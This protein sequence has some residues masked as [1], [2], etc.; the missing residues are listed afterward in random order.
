[1]MSNFKFDLLDVYVFSKLTRQPFSDFRG[2][3]QLSH[4]SSPS[5]TCC[6]RSSQTNHWGKKD[7]TTLK[8]CPQFSYFYSLSW[9]GPVGWTE[10]EPATSA[11]IWTLRRPKGGSWNTQLNTFHSHRIHS[12]TQ[13]L[14]LLSKI[15][16]ESST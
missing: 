1:M 6:A 5:S 3:C 4:S 10:T 15:S 2:V 9:S 16:T 7:W 12:Q 14:R 11:W 13:S 8:F